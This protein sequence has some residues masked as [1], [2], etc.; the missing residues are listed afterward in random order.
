MAKKN[1][2]TATAPRPK[3]TN[4]S[5]QRSSSH[6]LSHRHLILPHLSRC[7]SNFTFFIKS[8]SS[9]RNLGPH[10]PVSFKCLHNMAFVTLNPLTR[11]VC[12]T[13]PHF[14]SRLISFGGNTC[15][16][17]CIFYDIQDKCCFCKLYRILCPEQAHLWHCPHFVKRSLSIAHNFQ[18]RLMR[19]ST[20]GQ[21]IDSPTVV[22]SQAHFDGKAK[23]LPTKILTEVR[24]RSLSTHR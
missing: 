1:R 18:K 4:F 11:P 15:S 14:T 13:L 2:P 6:V 23:P 19:A 7:L 24:E 17:E 5:M 9:R 16:S 21:A 10:F 12:R 8:A 20:V 22:H 3:S